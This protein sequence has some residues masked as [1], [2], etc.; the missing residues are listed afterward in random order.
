MALT[1]Y[2]K[3][4]YIEREAASCPYCKSA[5]I[6]AGPIESDCGEVAW[7]DVKCHKC[8]KEWKDK[9]QLVDIEEDE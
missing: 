9:F 2:Q 4:M 8:G 6:V 1:V 3:R 5:N 7:S